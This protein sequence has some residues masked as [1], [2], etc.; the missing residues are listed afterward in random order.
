M[1]DSELFWKVTVGINNTAMP[2]WGVLLS[3]QERWEAIQYV[4]RTF[5]SPS[6]PEDVSDELP[7][8]LPGARVALGEHR[9]GPHERRGALQHAVRRLPRPQGAR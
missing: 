3:E 8:Q 1:P 2:Q 4:K 9:T 6:E 7:V 5:I